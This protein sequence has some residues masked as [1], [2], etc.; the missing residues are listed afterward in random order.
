MKNKQI[1]VLYI[2][3]VIIDLFGTLFKITHWKIGPFTGNYLLTIGMLIKAIASIIFII[4]LLSDKDN[5][6]LNK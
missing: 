4:K 6:F 5:N 1:I 2:V 3:G